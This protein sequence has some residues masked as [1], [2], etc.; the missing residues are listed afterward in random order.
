MNELL[1]YNYNL[2][3]EVEPKAT[4]VPHNIKTLT[5]I[6]YGV[7]TFG[8]FGNCCVK[9]CYVISSPGQSTKMVGMKQCVTAPKLSTILA[10]S[11][12]NS[13]KIHRP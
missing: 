9:S 3:D 2:L 8:R 1:I 4:S 13:K 12:T 7:K 11:L 6:E 5:M 10:Q